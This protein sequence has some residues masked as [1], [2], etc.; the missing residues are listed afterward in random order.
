EGSRLPSRVVDTPAPPATRLAQAQTNRALP[1]AVQRALPPAKIAPTSNEIRN[2]IRRF[3]D[4]V[5]QKTG[6]ITNS[7]PTASV[8]AETDIKQGG[9]QNTPVLQ[10]QGFYSANE[11]Y[12]FN[13]EPGNPAYDIDKN[14]T[15]KLRGTYD[16]IG[17]NEKL[18]DSRGK[19]TGVLGRSYKSDKTIFIQSPQGNA[20]LMYDLEER[21]KNGTPQPRILLKPISSAKGS[22]TQVRQLLDYLYGRYP[23]A[24]I[25]WGNIYKELPNDLFYEY[26][27]KF[28]VRTL[29]KSISNP[30]ENFDAPKINIDVLLDTPQ[31][32]QIPYNEIYETVGV[33]DNNRIYPTTK[34]KQLIQKFGLQGREREVLDAFARREGIVEP[35]RLSSWQKFVNEMQRQIDMGDYFDENPL[36]TP[37][38]RLADAQ[39][40]RAPTPAELKIQD[41]AVRFAADKLGLSVAELQA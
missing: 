17:T 26:S 13:I 27:N 33:L 15:N 34:F 25:D 3:I 41:K 35:S 38:S 30:L 31:R 11:P 18:I 6:S 24:V 9:I 7:K 21:V 12:F 23:N 20:G 39:A 40:Q 28:P 29:G 4:S 36:A 2:S 8:I 16:K 14:N 32:G 1:P 10:V 5:E 22:P 37:A 19:E